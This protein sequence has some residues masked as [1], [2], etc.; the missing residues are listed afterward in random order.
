IAYLTI[1]G[2]AIWKLGSEA[3]SFFVVAGLAV[4]AVVGPMIGAVLVWLIVHR[5]NRR[6]DPQQGPDGPSSQ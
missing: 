5:T 4:V 6:H 2:Y 3:W 1:V